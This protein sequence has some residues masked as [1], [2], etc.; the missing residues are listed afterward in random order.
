MPCDDAVACRRWFEFKRSLTLLWNLLCQEFEGKKPRVSLLSPVTKRILLPMKSYTFAAVLLAAFLGIAMAFIRPAQPV[1]V[2]Q[3][4][5][6]VVVGLDN[7]GI[8]EDSNI[9]P[10]RKCGFCMGVST[11]MDSESEQPNEQTTVS[12]ANELSRQW[13][14]RL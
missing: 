1:Q 10:A 14:L 8:P 6:A 2:V 9:H 13:P 7:P 11:L 4:G 12:R 5:P 3:Q